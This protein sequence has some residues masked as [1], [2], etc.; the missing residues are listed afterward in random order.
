IKLLDDAQA[1]GEIVVIGYGEQSRAKVIGAVGEISSE[2]L[3][4]V[5]AVS[6]DQ[7]ISGKM[8]GVVVN[9][10]NGQPGAES[11]IVIRGTGTLTAGANPLI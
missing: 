5:A 9:Q 8:A 7:Q 4:K 2:E 6:L 11:Q 3:S 1:L 10:F